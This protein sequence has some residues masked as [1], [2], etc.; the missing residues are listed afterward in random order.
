LRDRPELADRLGAAARRTAL[1]AFTVD[2]LAQAY[3][4]LWAELVARRRTAL[5]RPPPPRP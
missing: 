1:R 4:R 3:E 5:V 2:T